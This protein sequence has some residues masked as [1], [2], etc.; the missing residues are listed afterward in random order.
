ME[1]KK[2]EKDAYATED[3]T[4]TSAEFSI[5]VT[6]FLRKCVMNREPFPETSTLP[7]NTFF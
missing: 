4:N 6:P 2:G 1:E 3:P 5:F 7:S